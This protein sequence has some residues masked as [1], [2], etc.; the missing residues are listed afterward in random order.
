[1]A[2]PSPIARR[3]L[4]AAD[5]LEEYG[6]MQPRIARCM[7]HPPG[8]RSDPDGARRLAADLRRLAAT[9][10]AREDLSSLAGGGRA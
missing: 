2:V 10:A 9:H 3:L 4:E 6:G 5:R 1:M 8:W 7:A